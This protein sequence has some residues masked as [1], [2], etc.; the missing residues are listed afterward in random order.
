[1]NQNR[2]FHVVI[3]KDAQEKQYTRSAVELFYVVSG[4]CELTVREEQYSMK[5]GDMILVNAMEPHSYRAEDILGILEIEYRAILQTAPDSDCIFFLNTV[6]EKNGACEDVRS[7]LRELVWL[8]AEGDA[9]R[10]CRIYR[11]FYEL[12]DILYLHFRAKTFPKAEDDHKIPDDRKLQQIIA[13]VHSHYRETISLSRLAGDM[14]VSTSTLSRFFKKMTNCY[15]ADYV[16]QVRL[17]YALGEVR[18]TDKNF[19]RIAAECGFSNASSFNRLFRENYGMSPK[20]YRQQAQESET[21]I[22]QDGD[23]LRMELAGQLNPVPVIAPASDSRSDIT[24]DTTESKYLRMPFRRIATIGSMSELTRT[25]VQHH[26]LYAVKELHMTHVRIWSVFTRDLQVTDGKTIG[27]YNYNSI[28]PVLDMLV[29]NHLGV[30]FDFGRRPDMAVSSQDAA[31]YHEESAVRFV[32]RRAWEALLEDFVQHL[33]RR[34]GIEEVRGWIFDFNRD[35]SYK[36]GCAYSDDPEHTFRDVWKHAYRTIRQYIPG[37]KIGGPVGLPNSPRNE[38]S[39]FLKDAV[40]ENCVPDFLSVVMF[41]YTPTADYQ[42]FSR[43]PDPDFEENMFRNLKAMLES[44]GLEDLP[45]YVSDWNL[46]LSN[47]NLINDSCFRGAYFASRAALMIRNAQ[48]V[49]IWV[50]SDWVSSYYDSRNILNGGSGLLTRDSIRK[51][52]WF[53]LRFLCRLGNEFLYG[54]SRLVV[55]RSGQDD[56]MI[57]AS[58]CTQFDVSYYLSKEDEIRAEDVDGVVMPG[59]RQEIRLLLTGLAKGSNYIIKSR[60]VSRQHGSILDEWKR[61]RCEYQLE[62][63][64]IKYLR[65]ICVPHMEL[66]RRAAQE[67]RL[68]V[69]IT[70]EPQEF[71]L[72]HIYRGR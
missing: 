57:L 15:F 9:R 36:G 68:E 14:Y 49:S 60:S 62:S 12:M 34:Y 23:K 38:L 50:I 69:R 33:V 35:P 65:E 48:A 61:F 56:Y 45:V 7:L 18:Y 17:T 3:R 71:R 58:N 29:E 31:V 20:A 72:L 40:R 42:S 16:N 54:D 11:D 30:Y 64:D 25:N 19:T 37:A 1:M 27:V 13:Y 41:P 53:A 59:E 21:R 24:V 47:R 52:A 32:S 43:S 10:E 70:L 63:A 26:L 8:E 46:T 67:D 51:P 22:A 2:D 5:Q 66:E 28:D 39:E 55:T 4:S 44:Q 6:R